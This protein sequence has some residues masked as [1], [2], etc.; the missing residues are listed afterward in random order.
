MAYQMTLNGIII[1]AP[2]VFKV[3]LKDLDSDNTNRNTKGYICRDRIRGAMRVLHYEYVIL[4]PND[5]KTILQAVS[6]P[7]IDAFYPDPMDGEWETRTLYVG[8]RE[9]EA[10]YDFDHGLWKGLSFDLIED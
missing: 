8:D 4:E 3:S 10:V 1:P 2:S 6:P 7:A 5:I 9:T